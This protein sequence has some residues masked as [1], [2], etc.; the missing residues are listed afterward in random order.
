MDSRH[1]LNYC[2]NLCVSPLYPQLLFIDTRDDDAV[3]IELWGSSMQ[4]RILYGNSM[5]DLITEI[6]EYTGRMKPLPEW[7]QRGAIVGLEGGTEEVVELV[8]RLDTNDVPVAGV[9]LQD[10]VG[11]RNAYDGDRLLWNWHLDRNYYPQ[12]DAT[13][14]K[15]AQKDIRVLTYV[16]PFFSE[17]DTPGYSS[18]SSTTTALAATSVPISTPASTSASAPTGSP[19]SFSQASEVGSNERPSANRRNLLRE[20]I[21]N[22]YF[23]QHPEGGPYH[24]YS[25][26]IKFCMLDTTNPE[27]RIWMKNVLKRLMIEEASSSGWMADFGEYLP[28]DAVLWNGQS[29]AQYHNI[30]PYEWARI[31]EE[32]VAEAAAEGIVGKHWKGFDSSSPTSATAKRSA[33]SGDFILNESLPNSSK[34]HAAH[35]ANAEVGELMR[36]TSGNDAAAKTSLADAASEVLYFMRSAWVKSPGVTSLF[37]LGDQL[38]SWDQYDGIKTVLVGFLSGGIGGHSLSHSDIGGYTMVS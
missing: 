15:W 5:L 10:W 36:S 2:V 18:V 11:L 29:G 14:A 34:G 1:Q 17:V 21:E 3:V 38:V 9:W 25:G 4:G 7:S 20:G 23:V 24:M 33:A 28:F 16:N 26:S 8:D 37:W 19:T 27:A 22:S 31:N 12:W 6:T 32:A 35:S 30:Y 13:V